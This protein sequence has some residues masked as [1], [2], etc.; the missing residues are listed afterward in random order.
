LR[1]NVRKPIEY[2]PHEVMDALV[3]L[4]A[5]ID[6]ESGHFVCHYYAI[7]PVIVEFEDTLYP[8]LNIG[9]NL[10]VIPASEAAEKVEAAGNK[11]EVRE[12]SPESLG[13]VDPDS[14]YLV[15][16]FLRY[17]RGTASFYRLGD[18]LGV[19]VYLSNK[20][21]VLILISKKRKQE[22]ERHMLTV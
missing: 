4:H 19:V 16:G 12:I 13:D 2:M 21:K 15:M 20:K 18:M 17:A 10:T 1:A 7:A 11:I 9:D 5:A 22:K 3:D 8:G 14:L 6:P